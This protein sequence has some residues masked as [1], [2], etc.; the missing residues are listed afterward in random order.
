MEPRTNGPGRALMLVVVMMLGVLS[1][2]V[3]TATAAHGTETVSVSSVTNESATVDVANLN[4]TNTYYWWGYIYNPDGSTY[5]TSGYRSITNT[6]NGSFNFTWTKPTVNGNYTVYARITGSQFQEYDNYTTYFVMTNATEITSSNVSSSGCTLTLTGLDTT[7]NYT[8]VAMVYDSANNLHDYDSALFTP[9]SANM[10]YLASWTAPTTAGN[11][12]LVSQLLDANNNN[13]LITSNTN[14]FTIGGGGGTALNETIALS[15]V[16]NNSVSVDLANLNA[17][18]SYYWW[19]FVYYPSGILYT[20]DYGSISNVSG[21]MSYGAS[22]ITPLLNGNYSINGELSDSSANTLANT[23]AYF[24]IGGGSGP[25]VL[26][27]DPYEPNETPATAST[28]AVQSSIGNLTIHNTTDEDYFTFNST[29]GQRLQFDIT[30]TDSA[31][32]LDMEIYRGVNA[33]TYVGAS[34]SVSDDESFTV[35]NSTAGP[36]YIYVYGFLGDTNTYNLTTTAVN[37]SAQNDAGSGGDVGDNASMAYTLT[38]GNHQQYTGYVDQTD[39]QD[40][41]NISVPTGYGISANISFNAANDFDLYMVDSQATTIINSSYYSNPETVTSNGTAV[42]GSNVYIVIDAY[43]GSGPYTLDIWTFAVTNVTTPTG[44]L[45]VIFFNETYGEFTSKNL[46]NGASY[47]IDIYLLNWNGT[48]FTSL[49]SFTDSWTSN[50]S[51]SMSPAYTTLGFESW[52][53]LYG[54]LYDTSTSTAGTYLDDDI[55]CLYHEM[56]ESSVTSDTSGTIDAQNLTSGNAYSYQW[57]LYIGGGPT[58]LQSGSGNFTATG[59]TWSNS[60]GWNQPN[61]GAERCFWVELYY[62]NSQIGGH[63]DC[64]FPTWPSLNITGYTA[65]SNASLNTIYFDTTTLTSGSNYGVQISVVQYSTGNTSSSSIL[66]NFTATS[67]TMSFY[68]NYSTPTTSGYYCVIGTLWDGAGGVLDNIT[69]NSSSTCFLIVHDDDDDG[70]WN[71]NDLCANTPANATVD[72]YGCAS[73]QRDTDGDGIND[74]FDAFPFDSTQW[75]DSDADGYGDNASGNNP[76]AFPTDSTQWSDIDGDGYGDNPNG[77]TPD[78]FPNDPTEWVDSDGDGVGD[79]GDLWPN[80]G[81]QWADSDGDG[82][83]DNISGTN[84]DAFP[85]DGTQWSDQD[86]DG[87]GDNASGN[88]PD[89]FPTDSTQWSDQDGDGYGDNPNGNNPDAFPTDGTQWSDQDGDGYGDNPNGN[90]SDAFPQDGTQW[91]DGDGDGWGDNQQGNNPDVF[92]SDGTQWADRDGDGYGDNPNGNYPDLC[93]DTPSGEIVDSNG[94]SATERDTDNDGVM[95]A[96]D[97]CVNIDASGF[98]DDGDGCIDDTDGDGILDNEDNC[99]NEDAS[100]WDTNQDGCIDDSDADGVK[101][102]IDQCRTVDASGFDADS[103]GCIDDSDGDNIPDDVDLCRYVSALGYDSDGD[104]CIDDSDGDNIK[105]DIDDCRY[106]NASGYDDDMDG[107][108][109]D[110]DHDSIKDPDDLCPN[111]LDFSTTDLDGCS[112]H[113]RDTD[114][115]TV[116]D[117]SDICPGTLALQQV[118]LN[119]CS[120]NQRDTDGDDVVDADDNCPDT[121]SELEVDVF[122]CGDNQ[123]DTDN[124][125]INDSVDT[126]TGTPTDE[127]ANSYG[128]SASQWD[129]DNDGVVDSLDAFPLDATEWADSDG[130]GVGD[131]SD[132]FPNDASKQTAADAEEEGGFS[133]LALILVAMFALFAVAA[134]TVIAIKMR[135]SKQEEDDQFSGGLA[136]QSAESLSEMAMPTEAAVELGLQPATT[137]TAEAA[138]ILT[139]EPEQWTDENGVNWCR[140]PDGALLRWNGEAWEPA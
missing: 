94:C 118:D 92:P 91:E 32:D 139:T 30:F 80:D 113:Q 74:A 24:T 99:I 110:T 132:V 128:C 72:Q 88:N 112:D 60:A 76:D 12:S 50:G 121:D 119:G 83:G 58:Y 52:F 14:Y 64:F 87:Y 117:F 73:T 93:P 124:D 26:T 100:G 104:G 140:Q 102:D 20:F 56:L 109:D 31:G 49:G 89:A 7:T 53:C 54:E 134:I 4:V 55:D 71:E 39:I 44:D 103:D 130:D 47:D 35:L 111:T 123:R 81:S 68:W 105:D 70:V 65:D 41:Y 125:G 82:Y 131:N 29:G 86:G 43:T 34:S 129:S 38:P 8:W 1:A 25:A 46:S 96:Y 57:Y 9:S 138:A 75:Q 6:V 37:W 23:T 42:G 97:D 116:K 114:G 107:C 85:Q 51:N 10:T 84:G 28:I 127:D 69:L 66:T 120:A 63:E 16:T 135:S 36:Y 59:S 133:S 33:S 79:N 78:A 27:A 137:D 90:N 77:T 15:S 106:E 2:G 21:S 126:C 61:S 5:A 95:D 11:Y 122:G 18:N 108:I 136:V 40:W 98:D 115:D 13:S 101:D 3:P 67:S 17:S 19:T 62:N 48:N 22:W 45:E